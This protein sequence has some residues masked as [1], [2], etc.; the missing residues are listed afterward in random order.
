M[1]RRGYWV[2]FKM[3]KK[4]LRKYKCIAESKENAIKA[5]IKAFDIPN[6]WE[7]YLFVRRFEVKGGTR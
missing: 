5:A 1:K 7:K 3:D 2:I 6:H 4:I